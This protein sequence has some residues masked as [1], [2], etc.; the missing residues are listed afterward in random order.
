MTV[1]QLIEFLKSA[2]DL[3][4]ITGGSKIA[5]EIYDPMKP[6]YMAFREFPVDAAKC[7]DGRIVLE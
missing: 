7:K 5:F 1:I 2:V 3:G 6:Q 4:L